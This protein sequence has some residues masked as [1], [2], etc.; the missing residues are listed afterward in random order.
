MSQDEKRKIR[1]LAPVARRYRARANPSG[2]FARANDDLT[3]IAVD[4][5]N[6][7]ASIRELAVAAGVT[8]RAMARRV[9]R[10]DQP[11]EKHEDNGQ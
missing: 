3:A 7:G 8:Y 10:E 11:G 6:R 9:G 2:V 4:L 1:E 5:Y